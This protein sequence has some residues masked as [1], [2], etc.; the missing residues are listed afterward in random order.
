MKA[1]YTQ[2]ALVFGVIFGHVILNMLT[3][4]VFWSFFSFFNQKSLKLFVS[5]VIY[6]IIFYELIVGALTNL[7]RM[8]ELKK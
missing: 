6:F 7:S 8:M 4:S 5:I 2:K 1:R 3:V